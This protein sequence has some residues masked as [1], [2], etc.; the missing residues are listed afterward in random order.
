MLSLI[1][2]SLGGGP[3]GP[4]P[5][6]RPP[7]CAN[8]AAV[9]AQATVVASKIIRIFLVIVSRPWF[10]IVLSR[11]AWRRVPLGVARLLL[12]VSA[13][14]EGLIEI[15]RIVYDRRHN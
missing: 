7:C 8:A 2:V 11:T 12:K 14:D 5:G 1:L 10:M 13:R 9:P 4:K 6:P 15:L 3:G